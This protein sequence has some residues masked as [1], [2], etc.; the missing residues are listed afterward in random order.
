[1]SEPTPYQELCQHCNSTGKSFWDVVYELRRRWLVKN[2]LEAKLMLRR[3]KPS[4][5]RNFRKKLIGTIWSEFDFLEVNTTA[6][7]AEDE[8]IRQYLDAERGHETI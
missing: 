2:S 7:R 8:Q 1:M 5:T 3:L 4:S 6:R